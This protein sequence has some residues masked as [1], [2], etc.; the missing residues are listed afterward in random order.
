[1]NTFR[2]LF[3][4]IVCFVTLI[5]L[6]GCATSLSKQTY[7]DQISADPFVKTNRAIHSFNDS[8]DKAILKP[9]AT[10]YSNYV[11]LLFQAGISNALNNLGEPVSFIN[12]LLQF[13]F[14]DSLTTLSRFTF[15]STLGLGGLIDIMKLGGVEEQEEDFGQTLAY[16]GVK[17][18]P[19]IVLPFLGPSNL[20]DTVSLVPDRL[21]KNQVNNN[22]SSD[23]NISTPEFIFNILDTRSSLLPLDNI[24]QQQLDSYS[25]FKSAYEQNRISAIHDGNPPEAD[26]F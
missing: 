10:A 24:I 20:R 18:G 1:M 19:Y 26:D 4:F 13:K 15:N 3:S 17:P 16:W 25:F 11:P 5:L 21:L 23:P 14:D 22:I 8:V 9:V 12:N 7:D 2:K 6:T